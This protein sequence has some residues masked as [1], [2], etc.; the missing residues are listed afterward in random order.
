MLKKILNLLFLFFVGAIG[1]VFAQQAWWV[2]VVEKPFF[3]RL[4]YQINPYT[5][6]KEV[7]I[8]D[9]ISLPDI[10]DKVKDSTVKI[11]STDNKGV[12]TVGFGVII[13]S[14][15]LMVTLNDL[16]L[17]GSNFNFSISDK[18]FGFEILKRDKENNISLVKL[19]GSNFK[20][21]PFAKED[22]LSLG[23]KIFLRGENIVNEGVIRSLGDKYIETNIY[24]NKEIKGAP[25]FDVG[26]SLIG[27]S[28]I[29]KEG[30]VI[31]V[32]VSKIRAFA[33]F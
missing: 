27:I 25:V 21:I 6:T 13:T 23:R 4:N 32:P 18:Y 16:L 17:P 1:G 29:N 9:N 28:N 3:D 12:Q 33:G 24:D 14:D 2:F 26:G 20:T 11:I 5:E 30:R 19:D 22:I 15:G 31:F 8:T 10:I 7:I